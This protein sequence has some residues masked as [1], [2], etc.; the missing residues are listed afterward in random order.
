LTIGPRRRA[1]FQASISH[2]SQPTGTVNF[3]LNRPDCRS[4]R[5]QAL[6][7]WI[8]TSSDNQQSR[9]LALPS[10]LPEL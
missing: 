7:P 5:C 2:W 8:P 9:R 4:E 10:F 3:T 1:D 6:I